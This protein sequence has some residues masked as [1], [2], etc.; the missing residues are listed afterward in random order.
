MLPYLCHHHD[1]LLSDASSNDVGREYGKRPC[2]LTYAIPLETALSEVIQTN[3]ERVAVLS[4]GAQKDI[5]GA[6]RHKAA[7]HVGALCDRVDGMC[8]SLFA[9][10]NIK[11]HDQG[12]IP[13]IFHVCVVVHDVL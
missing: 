10:Q 13:Q 7:L 9:C 12:P 11:D 5:L 3:S 8:V 1:L 6:E 4:H 2:P